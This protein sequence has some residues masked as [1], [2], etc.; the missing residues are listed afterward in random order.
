[1]TKACVTQPWDISGGKKAL[2]V[3]IPFFSQIQH[4]FHPTTYSA[5]RCTVGMCLWRKARKRKSNGRSGKKWE[6]SY[7]SNCF[8]LIR[9]LKAQQRDALEKKRGKR[10]LY[11]I[12]I[13]VIRRPL[14]SIIWS[15]VSF[16]WCL[17]TWISTFFLFAQI[18]CP[19]QLASSHLW[20][21]LGLQVLIIFI[22]D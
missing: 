19:K 22:I 5:L 2:I 9:S 10:N 15:D 20:I 14:S 8:R 1:M 4:C 21:I 17:Y 12:I 13:W 11:C 7:F 18:M 16:W 6:W 3:S